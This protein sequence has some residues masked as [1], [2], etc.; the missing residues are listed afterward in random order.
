MLR[1]QP[2]IFAHPVS[3]LAMLSAAGG[4]LL[5]QAASFG[6]PPSASAAL[7]LDDGNGGNAT[8]YSYLLK[9]YGSFMDQHGRPYR[10]GS[11]EFEERLVLFGR[12]AAEVEEL[13]R[14]PHRLWTAGLNGLSDRTEEELSQLRGWRGGAAKGAGR[15]GAL[16]GAIRPSERGAFL[17][18][19]RRGETLPTDFKN[20][21]RLETLSTIENQG[22]C[23]SCWAI[24][25][26]TVLNAHA[27]IY[28]SNSGHSIRRFSTQELLNC[29]PNPH[30]C[31][32]E[33]GCDGATVELAFHWAMH[34]GLPSED[35][36]P[37]QAI[38][39]QCRGRLAEDALKAIQGRTGI[40]AGPGLP[41]PK[42]QDED[43]DQAAFQRLL[44]PGLHTAGAQAPSLAFGFRAWERLPENRY[45]PL[46]RAVVQ[47]GPV[48]VSV[49]AS[50]WFAYA[51]GIFDH[52]D[53]DA[54][55]DHA[56]T[57]IGF[58][59]DPDL[60]EKYWL[61]QNSWG[62]DWGEEGRMRL[63]RRDGTWDETEQCG[64]DN[65]PELGTGCDGGPRKVTVCGMCGILYD[66]VVPHFGASASASAGAGASDF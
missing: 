63:L 62:S 39:A 47:H 53:K 24:T 55:I 44:D 20:W 37:Y 23:G 58:G 66:S 22:S 34:H 25:S 29:V 51:T 32:G 49:A 45:E 15:E 3:L 40:G 21:T 46:M 56:V 28:G 61:I 30:N 59:R 7:T 65:Q 16:R 18:Q 38:T 12:R 48:G 52:C 17:R 6:P 33:G 9:R 14:R 42:E 57:L 54:I 50:T 1:A 27:E 35:D 41:A 2:S 43:E 11:K 31:G 13:N 10:R 19:K 5:A 36:E 60:E 64:E 26:T 4:L 8:S